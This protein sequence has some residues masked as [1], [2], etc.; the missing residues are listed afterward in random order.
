MTHFLFQNDLSLANA[1]YNAWPGEREQSFSFRFRG[2]RHTRLR[3]VAGVSK[4]PKKN[5]KQNNK[6]VLVIDNQKL[7]F[8]TVSYGFEVWIV[9]L[10]RWAGRGLLACGSLILQNTADCTPAL[11]QRRKDCSSCIIT[12]ASPMVVSP[13]ILQLACCRSPSNAWV[14][15]C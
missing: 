7:T 1:K 6:Q 15:K 14:W 11:T 3:N 2:Q 9:I 5:P 13:K 4:C 12:A 8:E 10:A